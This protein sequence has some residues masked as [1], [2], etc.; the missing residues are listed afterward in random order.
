MPP[1]ARIR[2]RSFQVI[3]HDRA[4]W[5]CLRWA[6]RGIMVEKV[7]RKPE[8]INIATLASAGVFI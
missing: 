5:H 6:A 1:D 8:V 7:W 4:D 3:C 2:A